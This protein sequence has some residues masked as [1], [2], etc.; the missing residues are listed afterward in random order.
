MLRLLRHEGGGWA[1]ESPGNGAISRDLGW[2]GVHDELLTER[3][4]E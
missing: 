2:A 3:E 1:E 4:A